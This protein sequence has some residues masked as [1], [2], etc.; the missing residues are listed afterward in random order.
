M[1]LRSSLGARGRRGSLLL[2]TGE[3]LSHGDELDR[4]LRVIVDLHAG[5]AARPDSRSRS[6]G[7]GAKSDLIDIELN[8][9]DLVAGAW[10]RI[11]AL[12]WQDSAEAS[13]TQSAHDSAANAMLRALPDTTTSLDAY[14][15]A[16]TKP[17][18]STST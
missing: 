9:R 3:R 15:D 7:P 12:D 11:D 10:L 18:V 13:G 4:H 6:E 14:I 5:R 16:K 2:V 1:Y 17:T 8:D